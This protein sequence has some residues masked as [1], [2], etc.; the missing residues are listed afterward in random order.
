MTH[1]RIGVVVGAHDRGQ[2]VPR[3]LVLGDG[4]LH[5]RVHLVGVAV[6]DGGL[7]TA[8]RRDVEVELVVGR[9]AAVVV[10]DR[11]DHGETRRDVVVGDGAGLALTQAERDAAVSSAV[12]TPARGGV[13][14][15]VEQR[16]GLG[17][18]VAAGVQGVGL[19]PVDR[20]GADVGLEVGLGGRAT[21]VVR[22]RLLERQRGGLVVVGDGA[23]LV[24]TECQTDGAVC[25]TVGTPVT[26]D[27][28]T[29]VEQR[30][31]F[32]GG[33]A[34]GHQFD[35]G[36]P[37][38]RPG[39]GGDRRGEVALYRVAAVVVRD[40]LL[41]RQ[42]RKVGV[43]GDGAVGGRVGLDR[44][45][46]QSRGR[47]R[48]RR[49]DQRI[50]ALVPA[51][52]RVVAVGV[53]SARIG[54]LP[55]LVGAGEQLLRRGVAVRLAVLVTGECEVVDGRRVRFADQLHVEVG[56]HPVRVGL[57]VDHDLT[58]VAEL[59]VRQALEHDVHD[60][61]GVAVPGHRHRDDR[62]NALAFGRVRGVGEDPGFGEVDDR[63]AAGGVSV[64]RRLPLGAFLERVDGVERRA[65]EVARAD[66]D[67]FRVAL[68]VEGEEE[69]AGLSSAEGVAG[70][71][72]CRELTGGGGRLELH[73]EYLG[74]V[75]G[76]A[77]PREVDVHVV[78]RADLVSQPHRAEVTRVSDVPGVEHR[79]RCRVD[80]VEF[81]V[82]PVDRLVVSRRLTGVSA[83]RDRGDRVWDDMICGV[84]AVRQGA[85]AMR[86][87]G[88]AGQLACD[89][90][91]RREE[92]ND[93]TDDPRR[94]RV[95]G[96]RG[97]VMPPDRSW[98]AVA[99]RA[100]A[101]LATAPSGDRAS[102]LL[103]GATE[104][105]QSS[106]LRVVEVPPALPHL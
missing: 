19:V 7:G 36:V 44:D 25:G 24:L 33:I 104:C 28:G 26:G 52:D 77:L 1:V 9:R 49:T 83:G 80:D 23:G 14:A 53:P 39:V 18:G 65:V 46:G 4:V 101:G 70:R 10:D 8:V 67:L 3:E 89:Q 20:V 86:R 102:F 62:G 106:S 31:R 71:Q 32:G 37:R 72:I 12:A 96:A 55:H 27:V 43:V 34:T 66:V 64:E 47:G 60:L 42:G 63:L 15:G 11:L 48:R 54:V 51:F 69:V 22:D 78:V 75:A 56:G 58:A 97:H 84:E 29:G 105:P 41:E 68:E 5:A 13:G 81:V 59:D 40:R 90:R 57:L 16:A 103:P 82:G 87:E 30:A 92:R 35:G 100:T 73:V 21:V 76:G 38:D 50:A 85:R 79:W 2:Q 6:C 91:D 98:C 88:D 93:Q 95:L 99:A 17:S 45:A 61:C 74:P 94:E